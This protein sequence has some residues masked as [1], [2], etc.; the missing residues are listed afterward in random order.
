MATIGARP[1]VPFCMRSPVLV[2]LQPSACMSMTLRRVYS[3]VL[4]TLPGPDF[5]GVLHYCT[6]TSFYRPLVAHTQLQQG[7]VAATVVLPGK[8]PPAWIWCEIRLSLTAVEGRRTR[9]ATERSAAEEGCVMIRKRLDDVTGLDL[10]LR[11]QLN[12]KFL[13]RIRRN[14][15]TDGVLENGVELS[16]LK[17]AAKIKWKQ[18]GYIAASH[19]V[20]QN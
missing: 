9:K 7:T 14:I 6:A 16:S 15:Y 11:D 2:H 13:E 19:I 10:F 5:C 3:L 4:H 20:D 8:R 12:Q 18:W 17:F 1:V